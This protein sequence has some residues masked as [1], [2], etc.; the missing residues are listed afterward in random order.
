MIVAESH[1]DGDERHGQVH[2]RDDALDLF[3]A[4][5]RDE[6]RHRVT[7]DLLARQSEARGQIHHVLLGDAGMDELIGKVAAQIVERHR[8]KIGADEQDVLVLTRGRADRLDD[9]VAHQSR[10]HGGV[11]QASPSSARAL[12]I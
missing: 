11:H 4:S 2:R 1:A 7:K 6:R 8:A 3:V 12:A 5:R 10:F 9:D